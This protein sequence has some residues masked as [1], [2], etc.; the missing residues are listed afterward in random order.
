MV[1]P[2]RICWL[3]QQLVI[4]LASI[5]VKQEGTQHAAPLP[6]PSFRMPQWGVG[7]GHARENI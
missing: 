3:V 1:S 2:N 6:L 4:P 7:A 5:T